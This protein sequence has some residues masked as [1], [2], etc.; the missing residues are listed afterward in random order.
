MK[1]LYVAH[2]DTPFDSAEE[3]LAYEVRNPLFKMWNTTGETDDVNQ[4]LVVH[5]ANSDRAVAAFEE[6]C[7]EYGSCYE[8]LDWDTEDVDTYIWCGDLGRY[9]PLEENVVDS[10]RQFLVDDK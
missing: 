8:G 10:L 6:Q 3:C 9:V 4:A 2:D 1:I 7:R 5:L